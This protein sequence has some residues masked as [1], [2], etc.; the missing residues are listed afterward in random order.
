MIAVVQHTHVLSRTEAAVWPAATAVALLASLIGYRTGGE[1]PSLPTTRRRV[2]AFFA[3]LF[4]GGVATSIAVDHACAG[5]DTKS[6]ARTWI[7][8]GIAV[9]GAAWIIFAT[10]SLGREFSGRTLKDGGKLRRGLAFAVVRHPLYLGWA[11]VALAPAVAYSWAYL[12]VFI[13]LL[14]FEYWQARTEERELSDALGPGEYRRYRRR[15]RS[16]IVPGDY[17]LF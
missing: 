4:I 10:I 14:L 1:R 16:A 3:L 11:L 8:N 12:L 9:L 17:L 15:T 5:F 2:Y 7:G 6:V 13:P